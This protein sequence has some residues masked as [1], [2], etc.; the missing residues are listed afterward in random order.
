M[1]GKCGRLSSKR[2]FCTACCSGWSVTAWSWLQWAASLPRN[3]TWQ[4]ITVIPQRII[5]LCGAQTC[6]QVKIHRGI[7]VVPCQNRGNWMN[8]SNLK[9]VSSRQATA[10]VSS[11]PWAQGVATTKEI[12]AAR[13][14]KKCAIRIQTVYCANPKQ[15]QNLKKAI[16]CSSWQPKI[17][18]LTLGQ[19][20]LSIL[21]LSPQKGA[22]K[23]QQRAS[24]W[25][26][27]G[28]PGRK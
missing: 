2:L 21:D 3:G 6:V 10:V 25:G 8:I 5:G 23:H 19:R 12:T 26:T 11:Q 14:L 28:S 1:S 18:H 9:V 27:A 17:L 16:L 15:A 7:C 22:A 20:S 4:Y 24:N 13:R